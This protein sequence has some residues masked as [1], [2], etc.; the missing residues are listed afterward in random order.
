MIARMALIT[1]AMILAVGAAPPPKPPLPATETARISQV[2]RSGGL[3]GTVL[4]GR[5]DR[6]VYEQAL[7]RKSTV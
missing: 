6:I 3:A 4:I 5:G 1:A 2:L 7:D